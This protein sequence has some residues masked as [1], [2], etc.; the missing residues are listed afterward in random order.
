MF[1]YQL[2]LERVIKHI[3]SNLDK[4]VTTEE[5]SQ[6]AHISVYHFH[7]VFLAEV[8]ITVGQYVKLANFSKPPISWP[9]VM[10]DHY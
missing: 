6:I 1:L 10:N 2:K 9:F 7:R 4:T 8:G 5:L 3:Q